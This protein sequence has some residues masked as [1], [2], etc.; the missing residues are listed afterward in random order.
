MKTY[1]ELSLDESIGTAHKFYEVSVQG[2]L[3]TIRY[4]RIGTDGTSSSKVFPT[5]ELALKEAQKKIK[6]KKRKGY[7]EAVQ[8][9]RK[10]RAITR[11]TIVSSRSTAKKAPVLWKF[12]SGSPA[13]GIY[14]DDDYC[15][16]GNEKGRIFKLNHSGEVEMQFQLPNGVKAI[17]IDE[18]WIYVGCDDGNVYDLTG[19]LP[20]LAYEINENI[21]IYWLD[22]NNGLL[23][24]SDKLG[25]IT[26]INAEDE[27]QWTN[28]S[29]GNS[30]WMVRC[31]RVG[32]VYHGHSKGITCYYG[33]DGSTVWE[34]KTNGA[35]LFGWKSENTVTVG[36]A[37]AEV[38][39]FD[40]EGK[41]LVGMKAD[42]GVFS[43]AT[44]PNDEYIFA[45]DNASSIYCFNKAGERLWKLA[46]TCGSAYSMQYH[47]EK[48]YVVT[49]NGSLAC[50]DASEAAIEAAKEGNVPRIQS[51]KAPEAVPVIQTDILETTS[52]LSVGVELVC[53]QQGG[54]LRMRVVSSGY[55]QD[56]N[57]Q[58]PKNLRV[59]GQRY[60]VD[61]V[62]EAA[63]GGFYRYYGNIYKVN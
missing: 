15:W 51:I 25:N 8:G 16:V 17:I 60:R 21:D 56:W 20:R 41:K 48:V 7:E 46:T 27:E 63:Q 18:G 39:L 3:M 50:I 53:I 30:G 26:V 49:T 23:G 12:Q 43:C 24:V 4:G 45:G 42:A 11:R 13:F 10:K 22:V 34:K 55:H 59:L 36:T 9:V 37:K 33:W 58:F 29:A 47:N 19:K 32:R 6:A 14:I 52:D 44:A 38:A 28:K 1:L 31:D 40:K 54:K 61:S 35:V 2:T 57:V 62:R 5:E